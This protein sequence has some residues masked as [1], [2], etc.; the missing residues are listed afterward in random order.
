MQTLLRPLV[1]AILSSVF[2]SVL[3]HTFIKQNLSRKL[4]LQREIALH[5]TRHT[6]RAGAMS[7]LVA[8]VSLGP[9]AV[10]HPCR[11][12]L[13]LVVGGRKEDRQVMSALKE[14][15]IQ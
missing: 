6:V 9:H 5:E 14:L 7:S 11:G 4:R 8:T 1:P 13:V 2:L 12:L 10:P 3:P 15:T